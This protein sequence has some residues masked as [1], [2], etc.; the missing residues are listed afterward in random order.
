MDSGLRLSP[1]CREKE[2]T[3]ANEDQTS[4][5]FAEYVTTLA[6]MGVFRK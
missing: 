1:Y 2:H 3:V 6:L 4:Q 5:R